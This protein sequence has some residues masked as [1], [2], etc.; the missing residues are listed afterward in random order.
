MLTIAVSSRSLF[1]LE[2][3]NKIYM[4][5]GQ[6]AFNDYM[7]EK[8]NVV[9]RPGPAFSLVRKLLALN[10]RVS[11]VQARGVEVVLLSRNSPDAGMRVMNS[12]KHYNLDIERA[13][14][15]QGADRFRYAKALGAHLFLSTTHADVKNAIANGIAAATLFPSESQFEEGDGIV[16][17]ALDGDAVIFSDEADECYQKHGL[18][19]FRDSESANAHIPLGAGPF[20]D[21]LIGLQ[22][23]Q[24]SF[25]IGEAPVKIAL[26]TAR[27]MPA[28]ERVIRTLRHWGIV[29]DEA[30]FAAGLS[31]GPLLEAFGADMFFDDTEKNIVSARSCN[32]ISGHVPFGSGHGIVRDEAEVLLVKN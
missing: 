6:E 10:R 15:S 21:F 30:F 23:L 26:V 3:G 28:H 25:S 9:L 18:Q 7:H 16:R 13:V 22:K 27:G 32:I 1:H 19:V 11:D 4:E 29:L 31:K 17:I 14:F 2:D 5:Q 8:E 20:K 12:I 24:R